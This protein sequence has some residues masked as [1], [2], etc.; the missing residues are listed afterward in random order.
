MFIVGGNGSGKSTFIKLL[1][2]LYEPDS[3]SI[4]WDGEQVTAANVGAYF[5]LFTVIFSDFHLF[6]RLYGIDPVDTTALRRLLFEMQL[7]HKV[8]FSDGRFSTTDLS[9]GQRKRLA[10]VVAR[11]ENRPVCVFDEW[12]AEQDPEFRKHYYE[13]LLPQLKAEGRTVVA[14]THD[15]RYFHVADKVIWMEEGRIARVETHA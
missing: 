4:R 14:I 12:A 7:D 1:T 3:G 8:S 2:A 15:E 6:D 5:G 9:S 13:V 11:L 10:M